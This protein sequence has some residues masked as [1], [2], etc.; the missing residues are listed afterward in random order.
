MKLL[1]AIGKLIDH[2]KSKE[3]MDAYFARIRECAHAPARAN[4]D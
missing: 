3:Y 1:T 4:N 2:P